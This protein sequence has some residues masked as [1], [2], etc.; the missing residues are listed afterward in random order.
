MGVV[1]TGGGPRIPGL[2]VLEVMA[3]AWRERG[4]ERRAASAQ[5]MPP[6]PRL[7]RSRIAAAI[8]ARSAVRAGVRL[9]D[10]LRSRLAK[11]VA[12]LP[13]PLEELPVSIEIS[14]GEAVVRSK[15]PPRPF[16]PRPPA[17]AEAPD[18][19]AALV[20]REGP[21]AA[22]EIDDADAALRDL[23]ARAA[24]L[25]ARIR[26]ESHA[27][28]EA[29]ASGALAPRPDVD[30]T[31]EQ[32]GRPPVPTAAPIWALRGFVGALALAEAWR[33]S[34]PALAA[35][36]VDAAGVDAALRLAP[37]RAGFALAFAIGAAAAVFA[38]AGVALARAADAL[39][40]ATARRGALGA[41]A[42]TV[43][44]LAAGGVAVAASSESRWAHAVL[45]VAVPFAA[46]LLA[47]WASSLA[48]RRAGALDAALA[49]DRDRA[50]EALER[51]RRVEAVAIAETELRSLEAERAAARRRASRLQRRAIAADR[52]AVLSAR[53]SARRL[54]RLSE[55]I[56]GALEL[57]RYLFIRLAAERDATVLT[58]PVRAPRLE[59]AVAT[60][61]LGIAS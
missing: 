4:S 12:S 24:A 18:P 27:F 20:E 31:P 42:A 7:A 53:A 5:R 37:V 36:G 61:R 49:W 26:D 52:H 1:S 15:A 17:P 39:D 29:L 35:A 58:A 9:D 50:R 51:G 44:A 55:G 11:Y 54:D 41:L 21:C 2:R 16:G 28:A 46:A 40:E 56:A 30:A 43:A 19:L 14:G 45:L 47:R 48:R 34:G 59:P 32:L 23:D 25:R 22:R 10:F 13:V 60:E 3:E 33:F 38:F 57:D 8:E 6:E